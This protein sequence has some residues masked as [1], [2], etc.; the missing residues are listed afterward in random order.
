MIKRFFSVL[1]ILC[2]IA[3]IAGA[4]GLGIYNI[5]DDRR[6]GQDASLAAD[7]LD[8][9][10]DTLPETDAIPDY[11]LD[12]NREM[13]T[14]EVNGHRY[15]GT[16]EIPAIDLDLPIQSTWSY[17]QMKVSPCR[18]TGSVYL[19]SL[20]ICGHNYVTHFGRLKNLQP[21][22]EVIFTDADDNVFRYEA[23][24]MAT[25]QPTAIEEMTTEGDWDLTLFTCTLGGKARLTVRCIS[26]DE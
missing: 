24:E 26:L 14:V 16:L 19:G 8:D 20:V 25:L 3:A 11:L 6:A 13:P 21:G 1:L 9:F 7:A 17:P 2:G 15:I 5:L 22:D 23:V 4:I 12:P 18:Y 10:R